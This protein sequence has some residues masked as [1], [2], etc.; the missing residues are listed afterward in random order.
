MDIIN[1]GI[2]LTEFTE[3]ITLLEG[4]DR[5]LFILNGKVC[6]TLDYNQYLTMVSLFPHM[7]IPQKFMEKFELYKEY[8]SVL[9]KP[10]KASIFQVNINWM[11]LDWNELIDLTENFLE[12]NGKEREYVVLDFEEDEYVP[13]MKYLFVWFPACDQDYRLDLIRNDENLLLIENGFD[14]DFIER[15]G[16]EIN[17]NPA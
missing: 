7:A 17:I 13:K 9:I 3:E 5:N 14:K 4:T 6:K 11:D 1:D 12:K 8:F 10:S 15:F 16:E 2:K